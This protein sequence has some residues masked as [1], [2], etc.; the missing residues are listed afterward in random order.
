MCHD[1]A[2]SIG[3][4]KFVKQR[5]RRLQIGDV[6]TFCEPAVDRREESVGFGMMALVMAEPGEPYGGAQ[7]P[8]LG[9]LPLGDPQSLCD[10][11]PR[12]PWNFLAAATVGLS[13]C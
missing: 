12:Q 13:A 7:F 1:T 3:Y 5:P 10:K 6:E 9:L 2:M 4:L 11:V 8:E